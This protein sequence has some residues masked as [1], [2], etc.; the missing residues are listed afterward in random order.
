MLSH[1]FFYYVDWSYKRLLALI[2]YGLGFELVTLRIL[3]QSKTRYVY[4]FSFSYY[5]HAEG[6]PGTQGNPV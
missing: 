2:L 1:F 3:S 5:F 4:I 6:N